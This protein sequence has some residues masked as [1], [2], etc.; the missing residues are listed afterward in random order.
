[1]AFALTK[2]KV[3]LDWNRQG[4]KESCPSWCSVLTQHLLTPE[5]AGFELQGRPLLLEIPADGLFTFSLD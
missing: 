2:V 4:Q 3:R 1:M 5:L